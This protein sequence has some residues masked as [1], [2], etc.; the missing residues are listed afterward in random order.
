MRNERMASAICA[1]AVAQT[2]GRLTLTDGGATYATWDPT[3]LN[4]FFEEKF[5]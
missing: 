5:R 3:I 1:A 4:L 2:I